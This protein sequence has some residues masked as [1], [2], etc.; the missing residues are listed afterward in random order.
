MDCHDIPPE[1]AMHVAGFFDGLGQRL[2]LALSVRDRFSIR[3][4]DARLL[5][6]PFS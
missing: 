2:P 5:P 6:H 3:H 1:T 4:P